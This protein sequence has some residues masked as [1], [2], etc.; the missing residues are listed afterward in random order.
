LTTGLEY[1]LVDPKH[2]LAPD[3]SIKC[4]S[5]GHRQYL[6]ASHPDQLKMVDLLISSDRHRLLPERHQMTSATK[7]YK[8][9][10][11]YLQKQEGFFMQRVKLSAG[12][13]SSTQARTVARV[14]ERY[15]KGLLHLTTRGSI[16]IHWLQ[17]QNLADV[18]RDLATAG[19][20]SRGACGGAVRG[21]ATLP[22]IRALNVCQK[23]SKSVLKQITP[24]NGT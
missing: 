12:V 5:S 18:K 2:H 23:N 19:L 8:L 7:D 20:T 24:A 11:I 22:P 15:A 14:S 3:I 6:Q 16:E 1:E 4:T 10:G 17:E 13:I 21:I 9:D